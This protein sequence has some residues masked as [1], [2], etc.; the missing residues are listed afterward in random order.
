[1]PLS[2][3]LRL[4]V[5]SHTVRV[6]AQGFVPFEQRIDIASQ[7]TVTVQARLVAL[8][9]SGRLRVAEEQGRVLDVV[10]DNAVVGKTPWVG[11][12]APGDHCVLLR[13]QGELGTP[14]ASAPVTAD[15]ETPVT[16]LATPLAASLRIEPMPGAALVTLDGVPLGRGS[17]EGRLAPGVH[18]VEA[19]ASGY[20]PAVQSV[21]LAA[22]EPRVLALALE[23]DL[24]SAV[25]GLAARPHV[26]L[27]LGLALAVLPSLGGQVAAS[28]S[29]GCSASLPIG[30]LGRI[31]ATYELPRGLGFGL[32]AGYTRGLQT[33]V[34]RP[35]QVSGRGMRAT[36]SGSAD[37][38]LTLGGV[39][40][41]ASV[42]LHRGE[43]WPLTLRLALGAVV[44]TVKDDREGLFTT[45][46]QGHPPSAPYSVGLSESHGVA[47]VYAAPE[48]RVGRRF[49]D[50]VELDAGLAVLV[51]A[52]PSP[53]SWG[54][55][56]LVGAGPRGTQGDGE[57]G[58]G[59]Q[60]LIGSL[61]LAIAPGVSARYAF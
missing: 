42:S 38:L 10:V 37:D 20:F 35:A 22:H 29:G 59:G 12:V 60:T 53:P 31:G 8:T 52:A 15:G 36:D 50:H 48:V 14:P 24:A 30:A 21:A 43:T 32:E 4:A 49:G 9:R 27:D 17:W 13:G 58:F 41:G 19:T 11:A 39:L 25:W 3:P 7:Q 5:G 44:A 16:L 2:G 55:Q 47:L 46:P 54:D 23:R 57:G 18:R 33:L 34:G 6:F 45:S 56:R 40:L 26:V 61:L 28:C 51:L 1:V